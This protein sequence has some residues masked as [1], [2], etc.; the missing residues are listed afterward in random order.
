M[1]PAD[2]GQGSFGS[3][4]DERSPVLDDWRVEVDAS[5]AGLDEDGTPLVSFVKIGGRGD[6][7]SH[8]NRGDIIVE[9][10]APPNRI[11]VEMRRFTY[12]AGPQ[13]AAADFD[14]LSVWAFAGEPWWDPDEL[15]SCD[16]DWTSGCSLRV[17]YDGMTQP[18]RLGADLKVHLPPDYRGRVIVKT[19]DDDAEHAYPDRGNV[20]MLGVPGS[21]EVTV[22]SGRAF[23]SLAPEVPLSPECPADW[24]A[25][26]DAMTNAAGQPAAWSK[27]CPCL[28]LIHPFGGIGVGSAAREAA[29]VTIDVAGAP[30][31]MT[32]FATNLGKEKC[33]L[34]VAV[35]DLDAIPVDKRTVKGERGAPS[36]YTDPDGGYRIDA[37][38]SDCAPIAWVDG[39][40]HHETLRA[41]DERPPVEQRGNIEVCNGCLAGVTCAELLE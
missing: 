14:A 3:I 26:C 11:R 40:D 27:G 17:Q 13:Q 39:P 4:Y 6:S 30:P 1:A 25:E 15:E 8:I 29:E 35:P 24:I 21:A 33:E 7:E 10:D 2:G 36:P 9:F 37:V 31:W 41:A 16:L 18:S 34:D 22:D 32:V 38:S 19:E 28:G 5:L 12:T 20:C 23:V